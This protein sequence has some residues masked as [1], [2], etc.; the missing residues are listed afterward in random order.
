MNYARHL[1]AVLA[2]LACFTACDSPG[3]GV[4]SVPPPPP[5]PPPVVNGEITIKSLSPQPGTTVAVRDCSASV[6][7]FRICTDELQMTFEVRV[8]QDISD[9]SL[10]VSFGTC[11]TAI[12]SPIPIAAD[13]PI[14]VSMP[15]LE[16]SHSGP[17]HDGVDAALLC[18][19]P[20]LTTNMVV[21][22]W[23]P[24][25]P[26]RAVLTREFANSYTFAMP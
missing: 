21:R 8:D 23:V 10:I 13:T 4:S 24:G 14:S 6:G 12:S 17:L 25:R 7:Y 18:E 1:G 3:V 26:S 11:A 22:V 5:P 9:A 19:L 15:V 20:A 2:S 16:L